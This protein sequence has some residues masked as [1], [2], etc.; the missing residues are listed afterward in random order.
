MAKQT[1]D[2]IR[3][4]VGRITSEDNKTN[5]IAR[6]ISIS[7][8]SKTQDV[9][10]CQSAIK[11]INQWLQKCDKLLQKNFTLKADL[12]TPKNSTTLAPGPGAKQPP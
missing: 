6:L 11:E 2:K 10:S 7:E 4:A 12:F 5:Y 9:T 3:S 8:T 1:V